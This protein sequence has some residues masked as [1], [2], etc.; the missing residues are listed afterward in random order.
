MR[1]RVFFRGHPMVR[2]VHPTT[3]EVTTEANLTSRGDCIIGVSADKGCL[4]L[5]EETKRGLRREGSRVALTVSA[6]PDSF[7]LNAR[8]HPGLLL[9]H[10]HDMVVRKSGFLSDRTLAVEADAA[11]RDI[12]RSLVTRLKDPQTIGILEIEVS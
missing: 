5:R 1:E 11:A 3:I 10:P 8:G 7:V 4:Q 6:G 9:S 12:P 2:S